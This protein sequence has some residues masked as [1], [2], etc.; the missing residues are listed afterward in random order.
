MLAIPEDGHTRSFRPCIKCTEKV[1]QMPTLLQTSH[2]G[3]T[4]F[5]KTRSLGAMAR[6]DS[7]VGILGSLAT[8]F[9]MP[10]YANSGLSCEWKIVEPLP[11]TTSVVS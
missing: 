5:L 1:P 3:P 2:E 11:P 7:L 9:K 8:A 10:V 6:N 4:Y